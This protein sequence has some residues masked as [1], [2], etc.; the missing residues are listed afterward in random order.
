M[1]LDLPRAS[2]RFPFMTVVVQ[3]STLVERP[4]A[5]RRVVAGLAEA[6]AFYKDPAKFAAK[7]K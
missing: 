2:A 1:L 5:V 7:I 3:R 4:D 6:T